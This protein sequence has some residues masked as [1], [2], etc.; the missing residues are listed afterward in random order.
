MVIKSYPVGNDTY[1]TE[2]ELDFAR[3]YDIYLSTAKPQRV[4]SVKYY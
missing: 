4:K 1:A 3:V 2:L